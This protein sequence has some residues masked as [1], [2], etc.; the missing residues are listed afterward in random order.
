MAFRSATDASD[1][2]Q[3]P[4]FVFNFVFGVGRL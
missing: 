2:S 1:A 3:T 4:R